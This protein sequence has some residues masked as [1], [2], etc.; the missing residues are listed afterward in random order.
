MKVDSPSTSHKPKLFYGWYIVM[1]LATVGMVS[2]GMGG[3]NFGLFIPPMSEDLGIKHSFFG[4]AQ[5]ARVVGFSLSSWLIGR[6]LDQY[7][8]RIPM[9]IAGTFMGL[10]MVG[11]SSIQTGWQIVALY[12]L[13]G[14]IGMEGGGGNLYQA[15]PLSRWFIR[16]RGKA[17]SIAFLGTPIGI[18]IFSP[19][20]QFLIDSTSWRSAWLL[21]GGTGSMVI[22]LIAF[23]VI[24]KDPKSMG[25]QPDGD[26]FEGEENEDVSRRQRPLPNEYSWTRSEAIRSFSFWALVAVLGLRMLSVSTLNLFRIPYYIEQGVSPQLVAWALSAEAVIAAMISIP[27]GWAMDRFQPRFVTVTSLILYII[28]FIVTMN[29]VTAWH[30]FIATTM[31]GAASASFMVAQNALWPA[32][33]GGENIGSIRGLATPLTM[34]FSAIGAPITGAIKDSTG[35]YV[36]AWLASLFLLATASV[37]MLITRK[38]EP[39]ARQ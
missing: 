3:I 16:R 31:F 26:L 39:P 9:A 4:W 5:T 30:V 34:V 27:T 22:V 21:L 7:G 33:F 37:L 11:L 8:A 23:F 17:I 18:F 6:I 13:K 25:L 36:P 24:R 12:L 14:M 10:I 35:T 32:Y 20:C 1:G 29:V 28:A 38:P 2:T 19:L 15:V